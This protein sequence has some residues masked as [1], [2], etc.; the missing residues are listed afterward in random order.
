MQQA[1]D[2]LVDHITARLRGQEVLLVTFAGEESDFVRFNHSLV[3]QAG[4]VQQRRV[5]L[6]LISGQR[7]VA[8]TVTLTGQA[9]TD[10]DRADTLLAE[11]REAIRSVPDDP[12]LLYNTEPTSTQQ[13]RDNH[14]P[15]AAFICNAVLDAGKGLDL[16]GILAT[17]GIYA[18]FGNSLGQRN[19][20][21]THSFHLD[22]CFYH[23]KDKAV[24]T[25]FAGFQWDGSAFAR[26]V[27]DA[28]HQLAILA[29]PPKTISPGEYRVY[30][31]PAAL[32][33]VMTTLAWGGFGLKAQKT[34]T[35]SLLKMLEE[36]RTLSPAVTIRENTDEG[37][38][39]NFYS[40]GFIKPHAVTLIEDGQLKAALTSPR[41][42]K[43]YA[44]QPNGNEVPESLDLSAGSLPPD[45]VLEKLG[46]GVCVNRLWYLNYSDRPACRMT[47]M[48]RFATFWVE[49]GQIVAPLNV[50]RFD[51]TIYRMLGEN[52]LA[53]T[54]HREL[55]PSDST[56]GARSTSSARLPGAL[57]DRFALT[58]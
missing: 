20:F 27:A 23:A 38:A 54:S 34:K 48:T 40:G 56:Y 41:S 6:E 24:K 35:T 22:F 15:D 44:A 45:Q 8:G 32:N 2:Q 37:L 51:D 14:L 3:R 21:A 12:Y 5:N 10:R 26:T 19:F 9:Q 47:G 42:A 17:G 11:L 16:V 55:L 36:G 31:A 58:L 13:I 28:K 53:L 29:R 18:G 1:F 50:M 30:L 43:E 33:E 52:L 4:L 49:N 46:T 7:H 25:T 57:I 39:P